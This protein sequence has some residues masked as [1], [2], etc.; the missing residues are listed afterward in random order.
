[1]EGL[2]VT[3]CGGGNGAHA[4]AGISSLVENT[5]VTV[6]DIFED[7]AERWNATLVKNGFRVKYRNGEVREQRPGET[8]FSVTRDVGVIS[9]SDMVFLVV[10][11][12]AHETYL[13]L[14]TPHL[15]ETAIVIG[16]PG[17]AGF[18]YQCGSILR[19]NGKSNTI[20]ALETLPWACRYTKYGEEVDIV[21]TKEEVYCSMV[22]PEGS[23]TKKDSLMTLLQTLMGPKPVVKLCENYVKLTL[24]AKSTIHPP[25][26]Y[27]RWKDWDGGPLESPPLF[28]QGVDETAAKYLDGV[29]NE[30][31][32]TAE[33]LSQKFPQHDFSGIPT[34]QDWFIHHYGDQIADKSTLV[35]CLKTNSGYEGLNH[36]M[37]K[38][39]DGKYV[40]DFGYRYI[41]EDIPYGLVVLKQIADMVGVDTPVI[42]EI[43]EWAQEKIGVIF[44]QDGRLGD[45]EREHARMP[46]A[47]GI[48]NID[49]LVSFF[50]SS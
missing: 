9:R 26:M 25:I 7:E 24:M 31:I 40:P 15:K 18:E 37:S 13:K 12:Y 42:N 46:K 34:M 28:Y 43:V 27:A 16:M 6:L 3:I 17:H 1:M 5:H 8:K 50:K 4:F 11:A 19:E 14:I 49:I 45:V 36:P 38:T 35:S 30:V 20:V 22:N 32:A 48:D 39:K 33:R 10:P 2:T 44:I 23:T 47:Y 21:G 29:N 41:V